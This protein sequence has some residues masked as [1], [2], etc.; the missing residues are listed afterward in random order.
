[1]VTSAIEGV[2]E[3]R[4]YFLIGGLVFRVIFEQ[5]HLTLLSFF[6][7]ESRI[8]LLWDKKLTLCLSGV[9]SEIVL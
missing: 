3:L 1:M 4:A 7:I 9:H 2:S 5:I 6:L 8:T